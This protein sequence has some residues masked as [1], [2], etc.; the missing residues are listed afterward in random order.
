[1]T[2]LGTYAPVLDAVR[3]LTWPALHRVHS[4]VP[5]PHISRVRGAT[6]EFIEHRPYRQGDETRRIDWKLVARTD[7]VYIRLSQERAIQPTMFLLDASASMAFPQ[8]APHKWHHARSLA[9]G[10]A[11]VARYAGDPVGLLV[12]NGKPVI[13]EPRT[14][15]TV[16]DEMMRALDVAPAGNAELAPALAEAT[17]RCRRLVIL[18]DFLGDADAL[19]LAGRAFAAAGNEVYAL[20]VVAREEL[21]PDPKYRLVEDPEEPLLRRPMPASAR[22]AYL[23]TFA[24]WR[25]QL[26]RDWRNAGAVYEMCVPNQE[27]IRQTI[28]RITMGTHAS[29]V[30]R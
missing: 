10:L 12:T 5:G 28:R 3:G 26:A 19:L 1:V 21:D 15:R 29:S 13:V 11:S 25:Q 22:A 7:R 20:H 16:L 24:A 18:T 2:V 23:R 8:P 9:I 14:R 27:P 6:V 4:A 30:V 17:R